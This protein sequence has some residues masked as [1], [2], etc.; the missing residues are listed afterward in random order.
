MA[1]RNCNLL[2]VKILLNDAVPLMGLIP[3][4][5][6]QDSYDLFSIIDF[7][8]FKVFYYV[9]FQRNRSVKRLTITVYTMHLAAASIITI[10]LPILF[11]FSYIPYFSL[12]Y[13]KDSLTLFH[14]VA[15]N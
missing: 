12:K 11:R 6:Y 9:K 4:F 3:V 14:L 15:S 8:S 7:H 13:F 5:V 2:L 1:L 10:I